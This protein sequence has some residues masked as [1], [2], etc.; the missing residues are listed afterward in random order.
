LNLEDV[1]APSTKPDV[2]V[3]PATRVTVLV[4]KTTLLMTLLL[5][6]HMSAKDPSKEIVLAP[7][8]ELIADGEL[9]LA[10]PMSM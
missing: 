7:N 8:T 10:V 9:T 1:P 5:A 2:A 3:T 6:S 4:L